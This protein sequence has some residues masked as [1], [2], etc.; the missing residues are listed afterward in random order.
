MKK[1][2]VCIFILAAAVAAN[3]ALNTFMAPI[4]PVPAD[5][6]ARPDSFG[7]TWVDNDNGG[8]PVYRWVDISQIGIDVQGLQ[9]DNVVGPFPIGFDFPYYWYTVNRFWLGSNGYISFSSNALYAQQFAVIPS[10]SQPNDLVAPL[11]GDLD[12]TIQSSNP[13]CYY[14]TNNVDSMV[15]SW[16]NV[17]EWDRPTSLHTFQ[18]ILTKNDS[19]LT[20]QYGVQIGNFDNQGGTPTYS[21][22]IG[23]EDLLGRNGLNYMSNWAPADRRPHDGLVIRFHA[24]PRPFN[25][26]DVGVKGSM[27]AGSQGVFCQINR[28][29][30]PKALIKNYGTVNVGPFQ[31]NCTIKKGFL[32]FYNKTITLADSLR[33]GN[34]VWAVF[35]DTIPDSSATGSDLYSVIFRTM[36]T[37]QYSPNNRDTCEM[38]S[39]RFPGAV[40][41]YVSDTIENFVSW[42]GGGGGWANE[43]EL[44]VPVLITHMQN[45]I[46]SNGTSPYYLYVLG[47]DANG[48]PDLS[49]ILWA[50]TV[51]R[52]DTAWM[53]FQIAPPIRM[54]ANTKFFVSM[55]SGGVGNY[56]GVDQVGPYSYRGWEY[57]TSYATSRDRDSQDAALRVVVDEW[58]GIEETPGMPSV[59]HLH[60]NYPNPFNASTEI[61]FDIAK[62]GRVSIDIYNITG[63][64][65]RSLYD[66]DVNAGIHR[67]VWDSRTDDGGTA[68]SG[69][70]FYKMKAED[71]IQTRKMVMIK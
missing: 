61:T 25:F 15:V 46:M 70:Y 4:L 29:F 47:A 33:R 27:N 30:T 26:T 58:V 6:S 21:S 57:T 63:Q 23:I 59:F 66:G 35:P 20:F 34:E 7:Y 12:F 17:R 42:Q 40:I 5:S 37:D 24:T 53:Q 56:Q 67:I 2:V 44:P 10:P 14:Y 16:V 50:D 22:Q 8:S 41:G 49:N 45:A 9:D 32:N 43:F 52:A 18:L 13:H 64:K 3:A 1:L 55:L 48:D 62:A 36:L 38:R 65:I 51:Q 69:V 54:P 71:Q 28:P 11:A 68:A 19:A 60:Q 39:F 31:V